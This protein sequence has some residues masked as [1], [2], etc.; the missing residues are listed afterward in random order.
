[1]LH[2]TDADARLEVSNTIELLGHRLRRIEFYLDGSD[3]VHNT[4]QSVTPGSKDSTVHAR[5]ARMK[6]ALGELAFKSQPVHD[7]LSLRMK[8]PLYSGGCAF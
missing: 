1:M 7:I 2:P 3:G 4:L 8:S 5:L 6:R